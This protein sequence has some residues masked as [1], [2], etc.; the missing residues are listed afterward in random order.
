MYT[1]LNT[2]LKKTLLYTFCNGVEF[3]EHKIR[4][5]SQIQS[6]LNNHFSLSL[7][8]GSIP[9]IKNAKTS[10]D[11]ASLKYFIENWVWL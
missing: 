6:Y 9:E 7:G 1:F 8:E 4:I 2:H 3:F 11:I 5:S 10:R